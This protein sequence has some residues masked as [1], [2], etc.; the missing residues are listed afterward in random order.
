M[1]PFCHAGCVPEQAGRPPSGMRG[2]AGVLLGA[3]GS[4]AM[5]GGFLLVCAAPAVAGDAAAASSAAPGSPS[6]QCQITDA[7]LPE[8][9]GLAV[10]GDHLLA[11]NDGGDRV[12]VYVLD[13]AC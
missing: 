12:A 13:A 4:L 9:S 1:Q 10:T 6:T 7:R 8:I 2:V 11:M 5:A 3:A